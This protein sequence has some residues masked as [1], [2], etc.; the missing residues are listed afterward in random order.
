RRGKNRERLRESVVE[1]QRAMA[2]MPSPPLMVE[3][4]DTGVVERSWLP[5]RCEWQK[6]VEFGV[7]ERISNGENDWW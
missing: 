5:P 3:G 2:S 1:E 6:M 4:G 7:R